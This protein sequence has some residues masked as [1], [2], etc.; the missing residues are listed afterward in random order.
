MSMKIA[1]R[2]LLILMPLM[3]V[4]CSDT[5]SVDVAADAEQSEIDAYKQMVA[6]EEAANA[7]SNENSAARP[8]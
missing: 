3:L 7:G 5:A 1:L 6:E 8:K 4:G 2:S